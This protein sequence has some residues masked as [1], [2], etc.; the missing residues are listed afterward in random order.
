MAT[1]TVSPEGYGPLTP[2]R[3]RAGVSLSVGTNTSASAAFTLPAGRTQGMVVGT[4]VRCTSAVATP[5]T[6]APF[7]WSVTD[8]AGNPVSGKPA[9]QGSINGGD[10]VF[11]PMPMP[12]RTAGL[13]FGMA[14]RNTVS[15][16]T[17]S[18][19]VE[20]IDDGSL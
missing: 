19:N 13:I 1:Q 14:N 17:V 10:G 12:M 6:S 18:V 20:L 11:P 8:S 3:F 16:L 7:D 15:G 2:E 9:S 4:A 5:S